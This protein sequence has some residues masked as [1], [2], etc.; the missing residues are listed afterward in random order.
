LALELLR[1][2][3]QFGAKTASVNVALDHFGID[4]VRDWVGAIVDEQI[5]VKPLSLYGQ[6]AEEQWRRSVACAFAAERLA[7]RARIDPQITYTAGLLH[8]VGMVVI[9]TWVTR[10]GPALMLVERPFPEGYSA[11]ERALLGATQA[12]VGAALLREWAMPDCLVDAVRWQDA[13]EFGGAAAGVLHAAKW[14]AAA[15]CADEDEERMVPPG[16]VVTTLA[17]DEDFWDRLVGEI[18]IHVNRLKVCLEAE[19]EEAARAGTRG[20]AS[21]MA[22]KSL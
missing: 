3:N 2:G 17:C 19:P 18:R 20:H 9:D 7:E 16:R 11:G 4:R 15:A 6:D 14:I 22:G 13:P 8:A 5:L 12:E 10:A 21:E 1:R